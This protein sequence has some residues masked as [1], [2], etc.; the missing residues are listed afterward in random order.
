MLKI[1]YILFA[2]LIAFNSQ[3]NVIEK[4]QNSY[5]LTK[6]LSESDLKIYKNV[7]F[8]QKKYQWEKADR[9]L[10]KVKNPILVGHFQYEKL[11][12][13]NKYKASYKELSTWFKLNTDY[14]PVLRK[15]IYY[16]LIKRLPDKNKKKLYKKPL[17]ENYL[18]GYGEDNHIRGYS[19]PVKNKYSK[20]IKN[21]VSNLMSEEKHDKLI[22]LINS[23]VN[24]DANYLINIINEEIKKVFFKGDIH[25][26]MKL[27]DMYVNSLNTP[28]SNIFFRAGINA[29]RLGSFKKA[30]SY[31]Q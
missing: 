26:S 24:D 2:F 22:N 28:N 25:T 8:Y 13:P 3:S 1:I 23:K 5:F 29:Y 27:F 18:R 30:K 10:S 6:V 20:N 12:H 15:R 9:A 7:I 11:M 19:L 14:P 17:F 21:K 31:F 16:L 4:S